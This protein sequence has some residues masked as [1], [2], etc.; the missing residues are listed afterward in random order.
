MKSAEA[1]RCE[2]PITSQGHLVT[3]GIGPGYSRVHAALAKTLGKMLKRA[4]AQ[5]D[6][7]R[8]VPDLRGRLNRRSSRRVDAVLDLV[9]SVPGSAQQHWVDVTCRSPHPARYARAADVCGC[10]AAKA[11]EEKA[12]TYGSEVLA[13]PFEAYGRAGAAALTSLHT[14]ALA[15]G[16]NVGI[17]AIPRLVPRWIAELIRQLT[18]YVSDVALLALGQ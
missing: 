15:L 1:E 4:G 8:V 11:A 13:I 12:D 3:C 16:C 7:E 17:R 5:V 2:K 9:V 6:Y 14:L 10:A 18:F